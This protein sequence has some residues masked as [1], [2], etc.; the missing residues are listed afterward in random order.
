MGRKDLVNLIDQWMKAQKPKVNIA[1]IPGKIKGTF[2]L[3]EKS[4]EYEYTWNRFHN[5]FEEKLP[6]VCNDVCPANNLHMET[7]QDHQG[8]TR[9]AN[10]SCYSIIS[11]EGVNLPLETVFSRL[12]V[13]YAFSGQI[14][15]FSIFPFSGFTLA[16]YVEAWFNQE[17]EKRLFNPSDRVDSFRVFSDFAPVAD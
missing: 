10:S 16:N 5:L 11:E 6:F 12:E 9:C 1:R 4:R 14:D 7:V 8:R 15:D 17:G 2:T 13:S 3:E